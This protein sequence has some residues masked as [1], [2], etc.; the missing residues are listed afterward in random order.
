MKRQFI[1]SVLAIGICSSLSLAYD[2]STNPGDGSEG[3]PY[4]I[5]EPN[6]LIAIGSDVS[7][8]SKHFVLV[9]AIVFDPNHNP[10]HQF[11][12]A[13]IAPDT[14][15][16]S[17]FQGTPFLGSFDGGG[18]VI[19]NLRIN[20]GH[21][22]GLFGQIG[23]GGIVFDLGLDSV[24]LT[25]TGS[26]VGGLCGYSYYGR[27]RNCFS[28]GTIES[29]NETGGLCGYND[30]GVI[31]NCSADCTIGVNYST[32]GLCGWNNYGYIA[33]CHATGTITG[34]LTLGGLVGNNKGQA[35]MILSCYATGSVSGDES[36]GG[37]CG[38][39]EG[40]LANS[41]ATGPVSGIDSLGGLCGYNKS[42]LIARCYAAG[43]VNGTGSLVGGFC[44]EDSGGIIAGSFWDVE[45]SGLGSS[46][47]DNYGATG[48]TTVQMQTLGTFADARWDF[49]GDS[50]RGT[51]HFWIP[52][53]GGYPQLAVS[54]P[55]YFPYAFSGAGTSSDP[56]LI[57]NA[58]D[59]G[60]V[61]QAPDCCFL[62][63]ND[64]DLDGAGWTAAPIPFFHGS[65]NGADHWIGDLAIDGPRY[66]GLIGNILKGQVLNLNIDGVSIVGTGD[67][68]GGL[69]GLM[70]PDS[71]LRAC[72]SVG[73]VSGAS[74]V[75]GLCGYVSGG[76]VTDCFS[77]GS[78]SGSGNFVGGLC[79]Y[80]SGGDVT[81][82][83]S[84]SRAAGVDY[85]G[86][87]CGYSAAANLNCYAGGAVSGQS[88]L[89]GLCGR[90]N[91]GSYVNCYAAGPVS[92]GDPNGG[93]IGY[94]Y[95]GSVTGCFWDVETSGLGAGGDSNY[96][97]VGKTTAQMQTLSTF[98]SA[99][100]DFS[101]GDGDSADWML[102]REGED[103]PRLAWQVIYAGDIAGLYGVDL[104]DFAEAA[105]HWLQTGCPSGCEDADLAPPG[106][107]GTVDMTDLSVITDQWGCGR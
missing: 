37:L 91:R 39:N 31:L 97:A 73:A 44:G 72:S 38:Y 79:G 40:S 3:N 46:G 88:Y 35:G 26:K 25:S 77:R 81:G 19:S 13:V 43:T 34:H 54:D 75:G 62:L 30:L 42:G 66:L 74:L 48:K 106:G 8:L 16:S 33:G 32:G 65:L 27:I 47:D 59:L 6:Q 4:Q 17:G 41:Y 15:T 70:S 36:L 100:W 60:A 1:L 96:G 50:T 103:Y 14:S 94:L 85:V 20:G 45:T 9:S 68:V 55:A 82:S 67:H 12:A 57:E 21:Y 24:D 5:S 93:F 76:S 92:G 83:F 58:D 90:G 61:W 80:V 95:L 11:T 99:G 104:A 28:T 84:T 51:N 2:W 29:I 18:H 89:G 101:A 56:Y 98:T 53:D 23:E 10:A 105:R 86:G 52:P 69:C 64:I 107:D 78:V 22:L 49:V 7:L 102:L 71:A 63:V 87:L